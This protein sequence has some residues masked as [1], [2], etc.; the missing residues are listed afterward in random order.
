MQTLASMFDAAVAAH[1]DRAFFV[2]PDTTLSYAE[3]DRRACQVAGVLAARGVDRG[4]PV[5]ILLPS[6]L[7]LALSYWAV[8]KVGAVA[9]PLNPMFRAPEIA[10][11]VAI[12]RLCVLVTDPAGTFS[13]PWTQPTKWPS[14]Y[15]ESPIPALFGYPFL[16]PMEPHFS[17]GPWHRE[18][19]AWIWANNPAGMFEP[20][21]PAISCN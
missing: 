21:N 17:G 7:D 2:T 4:E 3:F 13:G 18:L 1:P 12:A 10:N 11:A 14:N 5:G 19:H 16:G 8:Q 15:L 9:V 6:G 20:W